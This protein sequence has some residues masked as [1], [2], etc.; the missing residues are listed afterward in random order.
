MT[1]KLQICPDALRPPQESTDSK[2]PPQESPDSPDAKRQNQCDL[3]DGAF[4]STN[5]PETPYFIGND[6]FTNDNDVGGGSLDDMGS[7]SRETMEQAAKRRE[8]QEKTFLEFQRQR[9]D[10][11]KNIFD[12]AVPRELAERAAVVRLI[13]PQKPW[14]VLPTNFICEKALEEIIT[15][16]NSCLTARVDYE[17]VRHECAFKGFFLSFSKYC[18]FHIRIYQNGGA[19]F[20]VE[21]QKMDRQSD[22]MI[23]TFIFDMI[24]AALTATGNFDASKFTDRDHEDTE[25]VLDDGFQPNVPQELQL[26]SELAGSSADDSKIEASRILTAF[27]AD[28]QYHDHMVAAILTLIRLVTSSCHLARLFS[29]TALAA[30]SEHAG[31]LEAI[32]DSNIYILLLSY[33]V[34]GPYYTAKMRRSAMCVL[35]NLAKI[36]CTDILAKVGKTVLQD[37]CNSVK[38]L[39][40]E[41]MKNLCSEVSRIFVPLWYDFNQSCSRPSCA[42]EHMNHKK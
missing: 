21:V 30:L 38:T 42:E 37:R 13:A 12:Y 23:F 34:D 33:G 24:K 29:M 10:K 19:G 20:I 40:D 39:K 2:R 26:A 11:P 4:I 15:C 22:S 3:E 16:V 36:F 8:E 6:L 27:A 25:M 17:F 35:L 14:Y 7:G 1:D 18:D 31:C 41:R 5:L 32:R 28:P 9:T